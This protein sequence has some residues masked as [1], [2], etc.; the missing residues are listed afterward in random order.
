MTCY[1]SFIFGLL[2][3]SIG[4]SVFRFVANKYKWIAILSLSTI[5]NIQS[6]IQWTN[7]KVKKHYICCYLV[8]C[9]CYQPAPGWCHFCPA[10]LTPERHNFMRTQEKPTH[11]FI[12]IAISVAF[13]NKH[14]SIS[15]NFGSHKAVKLL[16]N[17]AVAL[18]P[19]AE[20]QQVGL[21]SLGRMTTSRVVSTSCCNAQ[22][23][24][25]STETV[26]DVF[27]TKFCPCKRILKKKG[28][29]LISFTVINKV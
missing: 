19:W 20:W 14:T 5:C 15:S 18:A 12:N 11:I 17:T 25:A 2:W 23:A 3:I 29:P 21:G 10:C 8:T 22:G 26:K 16:V 6:G 9:Q 27:A 28:Q 4:L 24:K 7:L 13:I 1:Y